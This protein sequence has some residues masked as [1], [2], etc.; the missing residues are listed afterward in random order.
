MENT[1]YTHIPKEQFEFAEAR[2]FSHD[3]KLVTKPVGYFHD[4][5][6]RF[7]KNKGSIVGAIIIIALIL[8]AII[9]PFCTQYTVNYN[10]T[11]YRSSRIRR[12]GTAAK[13]RRSTSRLSIITI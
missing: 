13:K 9:V 6:R 7:C 8:F 1:N 2:D 10:D 4:A 12:F 3:K 5:F 11:Y